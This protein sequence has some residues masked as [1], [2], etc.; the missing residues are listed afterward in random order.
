MTILEEAIQVVRDRQAK[1]GSPREHW[2]L[3]VRLINAYFGTDFKPQ[4]WAI[5]MVFDK[6]AREHN[7]HLRDNAVDVAGYIA[8]RETVLEER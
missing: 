8:G 1:Y 5:C 7:G 6:L 3:T 4:D 2:S